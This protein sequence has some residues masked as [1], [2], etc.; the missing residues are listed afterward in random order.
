MGVTFKRFIGVFVLMFVCV[1]SGA[2]TDEI[3]TAKGKTADEAIYFLSL[4]MG[5]NIEVDITRNIQEKNKKVT[6]SYEDNSKITSKFSL[7]DVNVNYENGSYVAR[8]NKTKYVNSHINKWKECE[9]EI[10]RLKSERDS[11]RF[12]TKRYP[13]HEVNLILG[14]YYEAYMALNDE[15]MKI[16]YDSENTRN[17]LKRRAYLTYI[18]TASHGML[19]FMDKSYTSTTVVIAGGPY[20]SLFGFKFYKDGELTLPHSY[21]ESI[22]WKKYGYDGFDSVNYDKCIL[23]T[24]DDKIEYVLLYEKYNDVSKHY[25]IIDVDDDWYFKTYEIRK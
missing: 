23:K 22:D 20:F 9:R 11:I 2:Q 12:E 21:T 13:K 3:Y 25:E 17:D 8:F 19:Y 7:P 24:V 10:E 15:A 5:I 4:K 6:N 14:Y 1:L 18:D 16:F